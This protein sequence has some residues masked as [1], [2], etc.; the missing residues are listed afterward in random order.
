MFKH[1][2]TRQKFLF[3]IAGIVLVAILWLGGG[4]VNLVHNKLEMRRLTKMAAPNCAVFTLIGCAHLEFL[5]D[6]PGV[7]RAKGE[8]VESMPSDGIVIANG[9]DDLLAVHNFELRK[10]TFG[11]G[12]MCDP[13]TVC[14]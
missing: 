9:D 5:G 14:W 2:S 11:K 13:P 12:E 6:R 7:L 8:I 10:V 1:L 4:I 3:T